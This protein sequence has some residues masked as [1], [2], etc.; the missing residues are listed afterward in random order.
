[1]K[2]VILSKDAE[3]AIY[4]HARETYPEECCG[5]LLGNDG[6]ERHIEIALPAPNSATGDKRRRYEVDPREYLKAELYASEHNLILLGIYH[7]HPDHPARPSEHDRTLAVP[8]FSYIIASVKNGE[9]ADMTSWQINENRQ[10]EREPLYR[11]ETRENGKTLEYFA[12]LFLPEK[13]EIL[14]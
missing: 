5:F 3:S 7:S 6:E 4:D 1:M 11:L 9:I 10:F 8:F 12:P 13:T 14:K 2:P